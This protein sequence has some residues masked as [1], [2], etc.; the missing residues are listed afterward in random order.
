MAIPR[1]RLLPLLESMLLMRRADEK[2]CDLGP[3]QV[4]GNYHVYIGQEATGACVI[5]ML[6]PEDVIFTTH[7]CHGHCLARGIPLE[8]VMGELL[9]KETGASK[10]KGGTQHIMSRE[11]RTVATSIVGGS[12]IMATGAALAAKVRGE[13]WIAV[14]FLGDRSLSEGV[15]PEVFNLAGL[16]DLPVLYVCENNNAVPY[17][18][19]RRS[20]LNFSELTDLPRTYGVEGAAV[21]ATDPAAVYPVAEELIGRVRRDRKPAFLEARTPAWPGRSGGENPTLEVTGA[22]DLSLAWAPPASDPLEVWH[23]ADPVLRMVEQVLAAG[24]ATKEE[25]LEMDRKIQGD[26][27]RAT[28]AAQAAAF[29]VPQNAFADILAGGDLWPK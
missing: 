15:V 20:N 10:G 21:D 9:V 17:D 6:E 22:T 27:E 29:P 28:K 11:W 16:W 4:Y 3:S 12:T 19:P 2:C 25:V 13:G 18:P 1:D 8:Q 26:V 14:A 5:S 24:V 7:R 23:R